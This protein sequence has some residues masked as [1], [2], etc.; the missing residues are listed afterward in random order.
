M[1]D[2]LAELRKVAEAATPGPWWDKGNE[3]SAGA[4][5]YGDFGW[6]VP[7]CPAGETEDS[8][9]GRADATYIATADPTT[10]L[11]LLDRIAEL[12][13]KLEDLRQAAEVVVLDAGDDA[14]G[15]EPDPNLAEL[16]YCV[17]ALSGSPTTDEQQKETP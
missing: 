2:D 16:A 7:G 3:Y 8:A 11:A 1:S 13:A 4:P 9:Q 15:P 17:A 5:H 6:C 14:T 10:V 12:E